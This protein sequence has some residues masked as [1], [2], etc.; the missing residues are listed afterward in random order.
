[1]KLCLCSFGKMPFPPKPLP[2]K[3]HPAVAC[4]VN[5]IG[6]KPLPCFHKS[7]HFYSVMTKCLMNSQKSTDHFSNASVRRDSVITEDQ[8]SQCSI[9]AE[10]CCERLHMETT[11]NIGL[12]TFQKVFAAITEGFDLHFAH[13]SLLVAVGVDRDPHSDFIW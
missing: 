1:M 2:T 11:P 12:F 3:E 13:I 9:H 4:P 5:F 7:Y 6:V 8:S 10:G